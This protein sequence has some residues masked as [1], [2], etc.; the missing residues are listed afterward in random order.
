LGRETNP[1]QTPKGGNPER[2][3][4]HWIPKTLPGGL[5]GASPKKDSKKEGGEQ[6]LFQN[7]GEGHFS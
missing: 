6:G 3:T 5:P 4:F 2:I 7:M 1:G